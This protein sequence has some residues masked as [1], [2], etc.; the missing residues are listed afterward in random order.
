MEIV[1]RAMKDLKDKST[2]SIILSEDNWTALDLF[3]R[4]LLPLIKVASKCCELA[5]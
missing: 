2:T 4:K 3:C 1:I 5:T